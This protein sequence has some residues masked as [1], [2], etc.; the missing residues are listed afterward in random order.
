MEEISQVRRWLIRN[1]PGNRHS[2]VSEERYLG[3]CGHDF[4]RSSHVG[5]SAIQ[6]CK[7][8]VRTVHTLNSSVPEPNQKNVKVLGNDLRKWLLTGRALWP[9]KS[10]TAED[11]PVYKKGRKTAKEEEMKK[12]DKKSG[13]RVKGM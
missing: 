10:E 8:H 13:S 12:R 11:K 3:R 2:I 5:Q 4:P 9:K 7:V 6:I 1:V